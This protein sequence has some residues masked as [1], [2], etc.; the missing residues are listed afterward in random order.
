MGGKVGVES[1]PG[2]GSSFWVDLRLAT[3]T[4]HSEPRTPA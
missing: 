2:R 3:P 1:A 4:S